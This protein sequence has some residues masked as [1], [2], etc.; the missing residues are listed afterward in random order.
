MELTS[1]APQGMLV[2]ARRRSGE[3]EWRKNFSF[4]RFNF[5][6]QPLGRR[7]FKTV[8]RMCLQGLLAKQKERAEAPSLP[9]LR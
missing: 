5:L 8:K 3:M 1:V 7:A 6:N 4:R 2:L 9:P